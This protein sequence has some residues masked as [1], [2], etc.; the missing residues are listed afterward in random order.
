MAKPHAH[1]EGMEFLRDQLEQFMPRESTAILRRT[2]TRVA[3]T[4]RND[5]R[6]NAPKDTGTLRKAVQSKRNRG[7]RDR[8]EASVVITKG[9]GAKH[10]AWY[11]HLVEFGTQ[12]VQARPFVVPAFQRARAS[13]RQLF[14]REFLQ[15]IAKQLEKRAKQKGRSR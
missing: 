1:I 10:D 14:E 2:V 4:I 15:Q 7:T 8:I 3:A 5:I 6:K 13:Y 12:W 9:S 11:W